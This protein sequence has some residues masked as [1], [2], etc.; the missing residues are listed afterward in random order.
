MME[1][2]VRYYRLV[3][4]APIPCSFAERGKQ[5]PLTDRIDRT[6]LEGAVV[7]TVFL[8]IAH[9]FDDKGRPLLFET[10]IFAAKYSAIDEQLMRC[11][12]LNEAKEM[13]E[14]MV[15]AVRLELESS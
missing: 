11:A 7:S 13:H 8:G 5:K 1:N 3:D 4:G 6:E 15:L 2:V 9:G 10:I 14:A 12:T